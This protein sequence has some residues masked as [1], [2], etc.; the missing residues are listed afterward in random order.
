LRRLTA[1]LCF[2]DGRRILY[3][4]RS[5]LFRLNLLLFVSL[6]F[7]SAA[8]AFCGETPYVA[9]EN[10][11]AVTTEKFELALERLRLAKGVRYRVPVVLSHG[12]FVNNHFL[13]FEDEHSLGRYLA[14]EGF[15]VWNLSFRGIGR[16]LN[17]LRD[18]AKVWT[19]DD[20]IDRDLSAVIGYVRRETRSARVSWVGYDMGGLLA[21]GYLARKGG[22]GLG[23]LVTIGAPV[24]FHHPEQEPIKKLLKLEESPFLKKAF[25]YLNGPFL[26]RIVIPLVPAIERL[27]YNPE[28][29]AREIREK[30]LEEG[31][32]EINPG[33]LDHLLRMIRRGEF[34]SADGAYNYRRNLG[35]IRVP[36]L[37]IGG[38]KDALAPPEALRLIQRA[39]K[40]S[41]R[42]LRVFGPRAKDSAAYGHTDLILGKEAVEEVFP[43]IARWLKQ[44]EEGR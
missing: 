6:F 9:R 23:A 38:E 42:S 1:R 37:L 39:V 36:L 8:R 20:M 2:V 24:T 43:V 19:L 35:R 31:L 32:A 21:Y 25:L 5:R 12:F 40:S 10:H 41:E 33:V 17:P 18:G 28:N 29:V 11:W 13:N 16:S 3:R 14:R 44:R 26:G 27:F 34:V 15:D 7:F 22:S 30:W 4:A